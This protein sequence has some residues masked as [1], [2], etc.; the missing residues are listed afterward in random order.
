MPKPPSPTP[1]HHGDL[2]AAIR[3]AAWDLVAE[4]G[5]RGLSLRECARRAGVSHA[6][7]AYHFGSLAGL[8]QE[9][10]ADGYE[11]LMRYVD[12]S[13]AEE[14]T[15]MMACGLG[16]VR[17]ALA[18]PQH[19]RLMLGAD[20]PTDASSRL[21][22]ARRDALGLLREGVRQAWVRRHGEAPA[23][24]LLS[25]RTLLGWSAAHGYASL[26]IEH[27]QADAPLPPPKL[28]FAPLVE[29]LTAPDELLSR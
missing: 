10:A 15:L 28:T 22:E 8:L 7:P 17:F 26:A 5:P 2:P 13:H 9:V 23:D 20:K 4:T 6:A 18:H 1:Y 3:R 29:A 24:E 19:F 16:Y 12:E 27:A 14:D 25:R 21:R 11:R